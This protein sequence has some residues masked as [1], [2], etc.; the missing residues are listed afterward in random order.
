[1]SR[2]LLIVLCC[3]AG[4]ANG[5]LGTSTA[6]ADF[7]DLLKQVPDSANVLLL[8]KSKEFAANAS[9]SA[10]HQV[11]EFLEAAKSW[12]VVAKWNPNRVVIAAEMDIQHME[13]AWQMAAIELQLP[14]DMRYLAVRTRGVADQLMDDQVVWLEKATILQTGEKQ[15]TLV[16]PL[17]RQSAARW[18]QRINRQEAIGLQPWLSETAIAAAA[19][20]AEVVLA[21]ELTN[22]FGPAEIGQAVAA[23]PLFKQISSNPTEILCG[24]RGLTMNCRVSAYQDSSLQVD[25]S[26]SVQSLEPIAQPLMIGAL[27]KAGAMLDEFN[28]WK[29]TVNDKQILMQGKLSPV[30]LRRIFDIF[31]INTMASQADAETVAQESQPA[32]AAN[33]NPPTDTAAA[34]QTRMQ[35]A[36]KRYFRNVTTALDEVKQRQI[37]ATP[38]QSALWDTNTARKIEQYSVLNVDPQMIQYGQYVVS[39]LNDMVYGIHQS[40]NQAR[41]SADTGYETP[42]IG[43]TT[44]TAVPYRTY[45]YGGQ[46]RFAYAPMV[47]QNLN[48]GAGRQNR[49]A[50]RDTEVGAANVTALG[51]MQEIDNATNEIRNAMSQKYQT[52]F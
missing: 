19:S 9:L 14:P 38:E 13:P 52:D 34:D 15:L 20:E 30:G 37:K 12:P 36:T 22:I 24:I 2:C 28:D 16:S 31:S 44:V 40:V 32:A 7:P 3:F 21:M 8:I 46:R 27:T 48:I 23:S 51:I 4:V 17:N 39:A 35:L 6:V 49:L 1:M 10:S 5:A 47:S 42:V 29:V 11:A 33:P 26:E 41:A 43:E 25:F 45:N 50:I 18:L